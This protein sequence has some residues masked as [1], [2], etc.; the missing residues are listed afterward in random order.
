MRG[1]WCD[2]CGKFETG[3][4]TI[5]LKGV[6]GNA[7]ILLPEKY[8]TKHFCKVLCFWK[9]IDEKAGRPKR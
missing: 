2:N 3:D 6:A 5:E 9:W 1:Y 8:H 7:G 4:P